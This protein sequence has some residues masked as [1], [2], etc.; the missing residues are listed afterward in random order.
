VQSRLS[1]STRFGSPKSS[2]SPPEEAADFLRVSMRTFRYWLAE[3]R[4]PY[5]HLGCFIRFKPTEL[6]LFL[7][8]GRVDPIDQ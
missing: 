7:E 6:V 1:R 5:F 2:S 4:I 8:S 3:R